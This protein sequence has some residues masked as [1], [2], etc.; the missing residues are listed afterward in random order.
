MRADRERQ[1]KI[2][3]GT[4]FIYLPK[5][6]WENRTPKMERRLIFVELSWGSKPTSS[7]GPRWSS[8]GRVDMLVSM[9][10]RKSFGYQMREGAP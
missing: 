5:H 4:L 2:T 3:V 6:N 1:A 7:E 10:E 9:N 8:F